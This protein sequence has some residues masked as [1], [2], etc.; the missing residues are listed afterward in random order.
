[1]LTGETIPD[2]GKVDKH[3][4]LR[5]AYVAQ[6]AFHNIGSHLEK[7]AVQYLAWRYADGFDKEQGL[8]QV[9]SSPCA[10]AP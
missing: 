5:L 8:K 2:S 1:M 6:H 10:C 4:N 7:S 3:P 9:R